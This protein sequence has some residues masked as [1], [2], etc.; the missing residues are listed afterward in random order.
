MCSRFGQIF[1]NG[2]CL[3]GNNPWS[4]DITK[5][6]V[7]PSDMAEIYRNAIFA[8]NGRG[9]VSLDCFRLYEAIVCGAIPVIIGTDEE[10]DRTFWYG[11]HVP[12][13]VRGSTWEEAV[14][15]CRDLMDNMDDLEMIQKTNFNW[16][17]RLI[18]RY[19]DMIRNLKN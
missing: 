12:I 13:F 15:K 3:T 10:I 2:R 19:R 4:E 1:K 16:W 9:N 17:K 18:G 14:Y 5:L 11:G 7:L 8:P 6:E